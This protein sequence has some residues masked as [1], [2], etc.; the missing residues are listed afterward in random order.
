MLLYLHV[1]QMWMMFDRFWLIFMLPAFMVLGFG[2]EKSGLL[3][4]SKFHWKKSTV[5]ALLCFLILAVALPKN[6]K[7]KEA[8]KIVFKEIGELIAHR[9][10]NEKV[11]KIVKSLRTPHWTPFYANLNY[12]GAPCPKTDLGIEYT[13]FDE[14]VFRDYKG[15]IGYLKQNGVRYFLWEERAWPKDGFDF[16]NSKNPQTFREIGAWSHPDTGRIILFKVL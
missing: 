6:L 3:I 2:L 16:M 5:L 13:Q 4:R 10:G 11:T 9:E 8:D 7:S 12:E 15:F 14:I 1:V